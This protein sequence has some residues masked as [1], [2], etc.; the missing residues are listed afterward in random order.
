MLKAL[1]KPFQDILDDEFI[2]IFK[3]IFYFLTIFGMRGVTIKDKFA[4]PA[5]ILNKAYCITFLLVNISCVVYSFR[6]CTSRYSDMTSDLPYKAGV[7]LNASINAFTAVRSVFH[8][9]F[10]TSQLYVKLQRIERVL[11]MR[12]AKNSNK[13]LA[14]TTAVVSVFFLL[15]LLVFIISFN[16]VIDGFCPTAY[17]ASAIN[18]MN[19]VQMLLIIIILSFLLQRARYLN[20]TLLQKE[21]MEK[22][23]T[24]FKSSDWHP[25]ER[26]SDEMLHGLYCILDSFF[27]FMD[28]FQPSVSELGTYS[29]EEPIYKYE[30]I[31]QIIPLFCFRFYYAQSSYWCGSSY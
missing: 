17:G 26:V 14:R 18:S 12:D 4:T 29:Y 28:V 22:Y 8:C 25:K 13:I 31:V 1:H 27:D 7:V 11:K 20:E 16:R 15:V 23:M 24:Y 3:P 9:G 2:D 5:S 6:F 19:H 10:T 30:D 21:D